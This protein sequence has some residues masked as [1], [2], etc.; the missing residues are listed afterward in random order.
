MQA[1]SYFLL[2]KLTILVLALPIAETKPL[3]ENECAKLT[4]QRL[5]EILAEKVTENLD[6]VD[7]MKHYYSFSKERQ[8]ELEKLIFNRQ[9]LNEINKHSINIPNVKILK[10]HF[11][12]HNE[13]H[14]RSHK[15][16]EFNFKKSKLQLENVFLFEKQ[17]KN[18]NHWKCIPTR[19]LKP[20]LVR[21]DEGNKC[22]FRLEFEIVLIGY[23]LFR[24]KEI[25]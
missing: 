12:N 13:T 6:L 8:K 22:V 21:I 18:H 11:P 9:D 23:K 14:F 2:I 5:E 10:N 25:V 15:F 24:Y 7:E 17:Y 4:D 19:T 3:A 20:V 16:C 1:K